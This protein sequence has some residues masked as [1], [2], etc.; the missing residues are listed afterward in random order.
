M[1]GVSTR[2]AAPSL[3]IARDPS[4]TGSQIARISDIHLLGS[5]RRWT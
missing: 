1:A 3:H 4:R 5:T 2:M